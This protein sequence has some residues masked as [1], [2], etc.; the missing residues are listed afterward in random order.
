MKVYKI[1]LEEKHAG[2]THTHTRRP[3]CVTKQI[4]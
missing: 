4:H 3:E 2:R 1:F